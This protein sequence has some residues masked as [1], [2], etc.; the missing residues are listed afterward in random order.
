VLGEA[1]VIYAWKYEYVTRESARLTEGG[2]EGDRERGER[3]I[4][5][6]IEIEEDRNQGGACKKGS[7]G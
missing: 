6:V 1:L 5:C 7:K 4:P 3:D 2:R